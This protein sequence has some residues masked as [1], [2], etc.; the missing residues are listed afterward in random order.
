MSASCVAPACVRARFL[1][2]PV[3]APDVSE[4]GVGRLV[5]EAVE[6]RPLPLLRC[7]AGSRFSCS[8]V[9]EGLTLVAARDPRTLDGLVFNRAMARP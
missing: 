4:V 1:F 2:C 7:V 5:L 6:A 8:G 3:D 9:G